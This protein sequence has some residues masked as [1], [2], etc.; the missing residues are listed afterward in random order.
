MKITDCLNKRYKYYYEFMF[1]KNPLNF[2]FNLIL[3]KW[4]QN[5]KHIKK[6]NKKIG[7]YIHI[8]YCK[9]ICYFCDCFSRLDSQKEIDDYVELLITEIKKFTPIFKGIHFD[10]LYF[11]GGTPSILSEK[12]L[13]KLLKTIYKSF[14]L[15]GA[16]S[17]FEGSPYTLS[18]SKLKILKK[19]NFKRLTI[20]VQSFDRKVLG[21]NN[22]PFTRED[23]IKYLVE[24]CKRYGILT[25]LELISGL[26]RQS[27]KSFLNDVKKVL[28]IKPNQ[29]HLYSFIY[30][31]L[32]L[33]WHKEH[34]MP[35]KKRIL[36]R[37][38]GL[39][40][41]EKSGYKLFPYS[42]PADQLKAINV[43]IYN[44]RIYNASLLGLGD[45]A[46]S[47]INNNFRY[48]SIINGDRFIYKK[49]LKRFIRYSE[50]FNYK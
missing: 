21:I 42:G 45:G 43:Q 25:N 33:I 41:V 23:L 24:K 26:K 38:K 16:H 44:N 18:D 9:S 28:E 19:F 15:K 36:W 3:N 34:R 8:P 32:T 1:G 48:G 14:N 13:N 27:L 22:R 11:G 7:L 30:N 31:P 40:L 17:T 49:L 35:N 39:K 20:G 5:L 37:K 6:E 10:T 12:C 46:I 47:N 4:K 50:V 29:I 2:D